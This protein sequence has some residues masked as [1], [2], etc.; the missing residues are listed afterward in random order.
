MHCD[1]V[2]HNAHLMTLDDAAGGLGIVRDGVVAARDGRIVHVGPAAAAPAFDA[3]RRIDCGGRWLGP[4][5][6]TAIPTWSMPAT[7]PTSSSSAC[8]A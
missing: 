4:A 5:W 8:R 1:T 6:S 3:A 2:W 7:A